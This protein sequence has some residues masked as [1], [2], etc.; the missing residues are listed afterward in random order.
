MAEVPAGG[1]GMALDER[2]VHRRLSIETN[3]KTRAAQ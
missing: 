2:N 3:G 1:I